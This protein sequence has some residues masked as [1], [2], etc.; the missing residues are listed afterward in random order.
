MP[1]GVLI[2]G[3]SEVTTQFRHLYLSGFSCNTTTWFFFLDT[4]CKPGSTVVID[5]TSDED[6]LLIMLWGES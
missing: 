4:M 1:S 2:G 6:S 3:E 5:S